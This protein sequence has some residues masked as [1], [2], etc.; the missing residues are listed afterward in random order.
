MLILGELINI[1]AH[2]IGDHHCIQHSIGDNVSGYLSME[3]RV[4]LEIIN[5]HK[6]EGE[7]DLNSPEEAEIVLP[8][9]NFT[10]ALGI[11]SSDIYLLSSHHVE[12]GQVDVEFIKELDIDDLRDEGDPMGIACHILMLASAPK[13]VAKSNGGACT[14]H[15]G[16]PFQ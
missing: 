7:N 5:G 14:S 1:V 4:E 2:G 13:H 15:E 8:V 9:R 11:E 12:A 6:R 16:H 3:Q 10:V